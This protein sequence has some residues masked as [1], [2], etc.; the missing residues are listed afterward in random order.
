M[1]IRHIALT[2]LTSRVDIDD[3]MEVAAALQ[4]RRHEI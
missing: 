1:D 3:L 4:I 2:T